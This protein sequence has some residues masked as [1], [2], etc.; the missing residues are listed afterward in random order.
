MRG[1]HKKKKGKRE[2]VDECLE[3]KHRDHKEG[4]H[5]ARLSGKWRRE[6]REEGRERQNGR[7]REKV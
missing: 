4:L 6:R 3:V 2:G 5:S 1:G 7:S